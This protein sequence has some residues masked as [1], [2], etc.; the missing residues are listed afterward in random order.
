[1]LSSDNDPKLL[2]ESGSSEK[3]F[4]IDRETM[5]SVS[6]IKAVTLCLRDSKLFVKR[7]AVS[8]SKT[9]LVSG[10]AN[11]AIDNRKSTSCGSSDVGWSSTGE[12]LSW[13]IS[14]DDLGLAL[15]S[16]E[17]GREESTPNSKLRSSDTWG[18][19]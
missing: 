13:P 7:S 18:K 15:E 11:P 17:G 9:I 3:A 8:S 12:P 14:V 19:E 6:G 1:M 10:V 16:F 5:S 2:N 4:I